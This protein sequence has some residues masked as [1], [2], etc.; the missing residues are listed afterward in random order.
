VKAW[1]QWQQK[2]A[3][4]PLAQEERPGLTTQVQ[5]LSSINP[6]EG[7]VWFHAV[8]LSLMVFTWPAMQKQLL[9]TVLQKSF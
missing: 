1:E 3:Q 7:I 8:L 4:H 6:T 2:A 5:K 9:T